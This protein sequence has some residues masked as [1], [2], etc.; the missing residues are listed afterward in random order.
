MTGKTTDAAPGGSRLGNWLPAD[1]AALSRFRCSF[2]EQVKAQRLDQ[3]LNPVVKDLATLIDNNPLLRM[4]LTQAIYEALAAEYDLGYETIPQLMGLIN[5]VITHAPPFN[6]TALVGC[7]L[8]ALLDPIMNMPSGYAL[9]RS[10][11]LNA[12][13][14]KVLNAWCSFLSGPDSRGYLNETSPTGWF[15][16]EALKEIDMSLFVCDPSAPYW[17]FTSWNDYFTRKFKPGE[18]PIADPD[19]NKVIVSACEATPFNIQSDV[20][21]QSRFWMKSQPYSLQDIFTA[22]RQDLAETYVGGDLYQA[23]LSAHNYHCWNAPIGGTVVEAYNV[24]GTYYSD[25]P[26]EG[27]DPAGPNLSQG[28]ITAVAARAV[29]VIQCDDTSVGTVACVFVGMA[30]ISSN[31]ITVRIGQH[32][33]KGDQIGYFQYG[34]STHCLIFEKGVIQSFVPQPPFDFNAT[35]IHVG[36]QIATAN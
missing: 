36:A 9:F 24:D 19:N 10:P 34:G 23:F 31:V 27:Y 12:Q 29:I 4:P 16:P 33:D 20:Q 3:E 15:C 21:L 35:P 30:E 22:P 11:T 2:A 18:R 17:G 1:E 28:Y 6:Q 5:G 32:V 13:L 14:K 8:N 26:A 7:P 25:A